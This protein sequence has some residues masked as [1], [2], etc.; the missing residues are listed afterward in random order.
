VARITENIFQAKLAWISHTCQLIGL[1][2]QNEV[3][4]NA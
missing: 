2:E 4:M 3:D 1:F